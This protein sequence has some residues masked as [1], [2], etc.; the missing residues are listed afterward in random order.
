MVRLLVLLTT[1]TLS[2]P[3]VAIAT[4]VVALIDNT[5]HRVVIAADCRVNRQ[6]ASVS[7]CKIIAEPGCTVAMA[8]LYEAMA[9]PRHNFCAFI[10]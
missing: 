4:S 5:N 2:L 8:G 10:K 9:R 7:K 3:A 6:L 1:G